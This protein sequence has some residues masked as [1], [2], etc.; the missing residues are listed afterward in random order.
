[1]EILKSKPKNYSEKYFKNNL[2][3]VFPLKEP[4][5]SKGREKEREYHLRE[6]EREVFWERDTWLLHRRPATPLMWIRRF[7]WWVTFT[8]THTNGYTQVHFSVFTAQLKGAVVS[9][10]HTPL[11]DS[12]QFQRFLLS[13]SFTLPLS[14]SLP[15]RSHFDARIV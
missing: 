10:L 5:K 13:F 12:V 11:T 15:F 8:L 3:E 6:R 14:I 7:M 4:G 2:S 1:M 9:V